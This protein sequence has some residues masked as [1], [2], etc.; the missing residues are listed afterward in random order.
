MQ[1]GTHHAAIHDINRGPNILFKDF[2][3]SCRWVI[4]RGEAELASKDRSESP[5]SKYLRELEDL[6]GVSRIRNR[7]TRDAVIL[8]L[9]F[10]PVIV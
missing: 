10:D 9:N 5:G 4:A 8:V 2:F 6:G 7:D 1:N 3:L